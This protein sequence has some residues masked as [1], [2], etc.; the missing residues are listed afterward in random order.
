MQRSTRFKLGAKGAIL[1][2]LA[3][4][5]V[6]VL[7]AG[8]FPGDATLGF[9]W[10]AASTGILGGLSHFLVAMLKTD[11]ESTWSTV[12]AV[13][14][15]ATTFTLLAVYWVSGSFAPTPPAALGAEALRVVGYVLAPIAGISYLV[16]HL[17]RA[18]SAA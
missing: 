15:L 12:V 16:L 11:P 18:R 2:V 3:S 7:I 17:A 1:W 4:V 9:S 5:L 6:G 8:L 14:L 13:T 10:I